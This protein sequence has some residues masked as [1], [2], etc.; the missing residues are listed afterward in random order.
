MSSNAENP[1]VVELHGKGVSE[2]EIV[3][4]L[5]LTRHVVRTAIVYEQ[6]RLAGREEMI[7]AAAEAV[8]AE[9]VAAAETGARDVAQAATGKSPWET[10][11]EALI[12][13]IQQHIEAGEHV[14][15]AELRKKFSVSSTALYKYRAV[16]AD[17]AH[18][19][20]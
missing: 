5:G 4:T 9:V 11:I 15:E 12:R 18:R 10:H 1:A 8:P 13:E 16:A 2:G 3:K 14:P 19:G 20:A 6:G 7:K 17:R